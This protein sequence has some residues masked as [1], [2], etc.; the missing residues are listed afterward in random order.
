MLD[1]I[2]FARLHAGAAGAAAALLA[3]GGD[4]RALH[5][6]GVADGDGDLLVGDEVFE[7][8][9]G[10]FVFDPVRRSSPYSFLTSSSSLTMTLRSFFSEPRMDSNSAMLSRVTVQLFNDFVDRELGQAMQLQFED[11]VGLN[12]S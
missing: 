11:R 7:L 6:A 10:G 3:V 4:R 5:V 8:D 1:E 9:L 12:S 2:L